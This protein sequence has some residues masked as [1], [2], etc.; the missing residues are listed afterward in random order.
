MDDLLVDV[1]DSQ[2]FAKCG[3]IVVQVI[4]EKH[5]FGWNYDAPRGEHCLRKQTARA[6][7]AVMD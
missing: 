7:A 2:Y 1:V 6:I 4:K 5:S 3:E